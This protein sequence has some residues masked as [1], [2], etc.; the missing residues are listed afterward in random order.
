M[1]VVAT[2]T[3]FA[4]NHWIR[5][6]I[7]PGFAILSKMEFIWFGIRSVCCSKQSANLLVT[8]PRQTTMRAG[9]Q[10]PKNMKKKMRKRKAEV[11]RRKDLLPGR[12]AG[13][14]VVS[15][16][17]RWELALMHHMLNRRPMH[18]TFTTTSKA[19]RRGNHHPTT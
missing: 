8:T 16:T 12:E 14:R 18:T 15:S 7:D 11:V 13:N 2:W 9:K 5:I 1:D 4:S 17:A 19:V 6:R 10:R 3:V